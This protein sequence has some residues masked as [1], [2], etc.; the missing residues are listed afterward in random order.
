MLQGYS[1]SMYLHE[2]TVIKIPD[3]FQSISLTLYTSLYPVNWLLMYE[4]TTQHYIRTLVP[5]IE[6]I[7]GGV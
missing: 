5:L 6:P 3:V 4:Q 7:S 2:T 1:I